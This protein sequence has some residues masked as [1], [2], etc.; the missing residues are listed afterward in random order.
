MKNVSILLLL[1]GLSFLSPPVMG[2]GSI[3][4]PGAGF[5]L[6]MDDLV[7]ISASQGKD[8]VVRG[9]TQ[10]GGCWDYFIEG[11]VTVKADDLLYI[12]P[13][14]RLVFLPGYNSTLEIE[15]QLDASGQAVDDIILTS[16]NDYLVN[17]KGVQ[18][19][20]GWINTFGIWQATEQTEDSTWG[21]AFQA[22]ERNYRVVL[23]G[24][25]LTPFG[26]QVRLRFR[27]HS[28]NATT[29]E[30]ASLGVRRVSGGDPFDFA[31]IPRR[32]TF[33]DRNNGVELPAG[34][35]TWS[36]WVDYSFTAGTDYLV[37]LKVPANHYPR[38]LSDPGRTHQYFKNSSEDETSLV[39]VTGYTPSGEL[40][41][42]QEIEGRIPDV[43]MTYV[44]QR[45]DGVFFDGLPG[46]WQGSV[47]QLNAAR[48]WYWEESI[49]YVYSA[50]NPDTAYTAPGI[51]IGYLPLP[52]GVS[53]GF[54]RV[55][56]EAVDAEAEEAELLEVAMTSDLTTHK[57]IFAITSISGVT[58]PAAG[59]WYALTFRFLEGQ[60]TSLVRYVTIR[61]ADIG[62]NCLNVPEDTLTI[63]QCTIEWN[64]TGIYLVNSS[65]L[66]QDNRDISYHRIEIDALGR[67]V[68]SSGSGIY[69]QGG[70][71]PLVRRN[72]FIGNQGNVILIAGKGVTP[73][74]PLPK[75]GGPFTH[76]DVG[77]NNF[78]IHYNDPPFNTEAGR[79]GQRHVYNETANT[80][81]ALYNY[82][83][84]SDPSYINTVLIYDDTQDSQSGPVIFQPF[85]VRPRSEVGEETWSD[86]R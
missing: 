47:S 43:W 38:F 70:S 50:S 44:S 68:R 60:P 7:N 16:A 35:L 52:A 80:I 86:Y 65:P 54:S 21:N 55:M 63:E 9:T 18:R 82:W 30:G 27:G 10:I 37:H 76:G 20:G 23:R 1:L 49:L 15:G 58:G 57:G 71:N 79:V 8:T 66:I 61:G 75:L 28:A 4:T 46:T 59:D 13:G 42:L 11:T 17:I 72:T 64:H 12:Q 77:A 84:T 25:S 69:L 3:V 33:Q 29:L 34:S 31:A 83:G 26:T 81:Y 51:E 6:S 19:I 78:L 2:S 22:N 48:E 14:E 73:V 32:I 56:D 5:V 74:T 40:Y 45:P 53:S 62:I 41:W 67:I 36:D 39:D 24:D 85:S